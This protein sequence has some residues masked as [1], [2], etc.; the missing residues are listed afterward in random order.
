MYLCKNVVLDFFELLN[1]NS[2]K[3][4]LI[5]NVNCELPD[6]LS[7]GKDIDILVWPDDYTKYKMVMHNNK[8][9]RIVHP[10]GSKHGW[11]FLYGVKEFIKFKNIKT[12]LEID[13]C[14]QICTK[15]INMNAWIPLDKAINMSIWKNRVWDKKNSWWIMD[16]ENLVVYLITR[17]VFEK[18]AFNSQY[19]Y[20]IKCRKHFLEKNECIEK[21]NLIFFSFTNELIKLIKNDD[22][23]KIQNTYMKFTKY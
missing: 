22:Y 23:E 14:F 13:A 1:K 20:E 19:I 2:I 7:K 21:L 10:E 12:G 16:D 9:S 17:C 4:V 3:Y 15:S 6:K 18:N 8:F 5:K 11:L